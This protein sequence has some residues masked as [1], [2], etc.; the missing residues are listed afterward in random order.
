MLISKMLKESL[1]CD[2]LKFST[3]D[4]KYT[5]YQYQKVSNSIYL[6]MHYSFQYFVC[7]MFSFMKKY[8]LL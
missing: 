5:K 4:G 2:E 6:K 3:Q 8:T 7:A 1:G